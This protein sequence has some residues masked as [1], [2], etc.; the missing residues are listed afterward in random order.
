VLTANNTM[1]C[2]FPTIPAAWS[3]STETTMASESLLNR[4]VSNDP[5]MPLTSCWSISSP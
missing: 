4:L 1:T 5:S 3:A 2:V